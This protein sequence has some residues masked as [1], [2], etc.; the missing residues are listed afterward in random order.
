MVYRRHKAWWIKSVKG[1]IEDDLLCRCDNVVEHR[2]V[3]E[4]VR[5]LAGGLHRM[6]EEWELRQAEHGNGD[7]TP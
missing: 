7:P 3:F 4:A 5:S 1:W 6:L 2:E